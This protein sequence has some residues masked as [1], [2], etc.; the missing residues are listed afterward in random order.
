[1]VITEKEELLQD[2]IGL[3]LRLKGDRR[4]WNGDV[5]LSPT[6]RE[7]VNEFIARYSV[8]KLKGEVPA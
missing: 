3:L 8:L 2:A 7:D 4:V 1:V 6:Q 5:G